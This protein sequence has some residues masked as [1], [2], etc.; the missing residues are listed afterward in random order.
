MKKTTLLS[1]GTAVISAAIISFVTYGC[2]DDDVAAKPKTDGGTSSSGGSSGGSSGS[3]G[4]DGGKPSP[5]NLGAQIDRMG[6]AAI[7]TAVNNTFNLNSTQADQKKDEW[8]A[9][10]DPSGWVAKYR[11]EIAA[12]LAIY[13]SL[14]TATTDGDGCGNQLLISQDAGATTNIDKYGGLASVLADDRV[15]LNT[16]GTTASQYLAVELNAVGVANTDR[17]GRTLAYDVIQ[18]TYSAVAVGAT[19]GVDDTITA[20]PAKTGGTAFPYLASP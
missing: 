11:A 9:D 17:G 6:R 5:P 3:S 2:G 19:T 16:A 18:T 10:K 14:D 20:D 7:N 4:N 12:N 8:N 1:F 15:W 13:D